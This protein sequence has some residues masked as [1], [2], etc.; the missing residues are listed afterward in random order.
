MKSSKEEI[1]RQV[2]RHTHSPSEKMKAG[3]GLLSNVQ[4]L[5]AFKNAP[6][7]LSFLS[8]D[9]EISTEEITKS[10]MNSSK[11]LALPRICENGMDFYI[12]T[13]DK[14]L[15]HQ[16]ETGQYKIREPKKNLLLL[17]K[18]D[19]DP[20]CV[21]LF[22]GRAFTA[23]GKRLGRGK[24]YYDKYFLPFLSELKHQKPLFIGTCYEAQITG[25]IPCESHDIVMDCI[26]TEQ[27]I[28]FCLKP[29]L[30]A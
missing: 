28:R 25:T 14:S 22:P 23:D 3:L 9:D 5:E 27:N 15:E 2:A 10:I 29:P 1:R 12:L 16:I 7:I 20:S 17:Q 18:T 24:G 26:V 13:H 11:R 21:V 6:T 8:L 30:H 4:N 19:I